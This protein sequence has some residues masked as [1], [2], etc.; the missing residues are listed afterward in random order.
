MEDNVD[1]VL[2]NLILTEMVEAKRHVKNAP[3]IVKTTYAT[4]ELQ[5]NFPEVNTI[6]KSE[7]T[8]LIN[9]TLFTG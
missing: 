5:V 2:G 8:T 6:K 4:N 9:I 7:T 3:S 1:R